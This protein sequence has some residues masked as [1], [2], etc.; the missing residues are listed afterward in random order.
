MSNKTTVNSK[1][2]SSWLST[3]PDY[4]VDFIRHKMFY[5]S[6]NTIRIYISNIHVFWDW[7]NNIGYDN[8]LNAMS[9]VDETMCNS[10]LSYLVD[11]RNFSISTISS[12]F[13]TINSLYDFM[14]SHKYATSNPLANIERP[15]QEK[16]KH[17]GLTNDEKI[18]FLHVVSSGENM[19]K[20]FISQEL[21]HGTHARNVAI[22]R[23]L[24]DANIKISELV[25]LNVEDVD[26]RSHCIILNGKEIP[27]SSDTESA[28]Q[29]YLDIR[30]AL[31]IPSSE[32]SLF[33][34]SQ[35]RNKDKRISIQTVDTLI[36]KYAFAAGIISDFSPNKLRYT[37]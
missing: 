9:T 14:V 26:F 11:K 29:E 21:T 10:F 35:G 22:A 16:V 6:T 8:S 17:S 33:L 4:A 3:L 7:L 12:V 36:K 1:A 23:L 37:D 18:R 32:R 34:A 28:I 2:I 5:N 27:I 19:P 20:R 25:S 13:S 15:K 24:I 31:C 30:I